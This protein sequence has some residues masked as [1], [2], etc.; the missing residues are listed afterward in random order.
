MKR[1]VLYLF[2]T[3]AALAVPAQQAYITGSIPQYIGGQISEKPVGGGD[4]IQSYPLNPTGGFN[5]Q[6]TATP[7]HAITVT[8]PYGS[9]YSSFTVTVTIPVYGS[10]NISTA[11]QSSIPIPKPQ[12]FPA[13]Q[14]GTYSFGVGLLSYQWPSSQV[15]GCL[16]N[17]GAGSLT[18]AACGSGGGSI[19]GLIAAGMNVTITG[20]GTSGSPYFINSTGG[21]ASL[22]ANLSGVATNSSGVGVQQTSTQAEA[23][24]ASD[25]ANNSV[26]GWKLGSGGDS[27]VP[28]PTLG[29]WYM[30]YKSSMLQASHNGSAFSAAFPLSCQPGLGD[31]FDAITAGTY[32]QTTCRNET[33]FTWNLTSIKCV[34][35][36]GASTCN[37][38]NGSGTGLL[39]AAVAG[40]PSY[41]NGTQSATTTIAPGDYI[42]VTFVA[43]GTSKQIGIDLAGW[44]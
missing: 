19:T 17:D 40:S 2:I 12:T 44:Y 27:N 1:A 18:W 23:I 14:V 39:T 30:A 38:T 22:P 3:L 34:E 35:D 4:R 13:L 10:T 7:Q 42:K 25:T 33:G 15:S 36:T 6:V 32:P 29:Y 37:A 41:A 5:F 20:S 31:G 43:D 8:P 9:P 24:L 28:T 26:V 21:G 16:T 11:L